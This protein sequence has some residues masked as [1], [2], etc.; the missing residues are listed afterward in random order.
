MRNYSN[1]SVE[2][3]FKLY[4]VHDEE[5]SAI[6]SFALA[7]PEPVRELFL[8]IKK[9]NA[10]AMGL[11][12]SPFNGSQYIRVFKVDVQ[13]ASAKFL[14]Y[15]PFC[16]ESF[17]SYIDDLAAVKTEDPKLLQNIIEVELKK[18]KEGGTSLYSLAGC[19][20]SAS[21]SMPELYSCCR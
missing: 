2:D 21:G 19:F 13:G 4:V 5:R 18:C 20:S 12:P 14:V 7:L 3:L 8:N 15:N 1:L 16:F 9:R 6:D 10:A 17:R 11:E